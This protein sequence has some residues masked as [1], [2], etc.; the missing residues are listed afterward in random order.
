MTRK[1][2]DVITGLGQRLLKVMVLACHKLSSESTKV[3]RNC[4]CT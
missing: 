1:K 4:L 3:T 2:W